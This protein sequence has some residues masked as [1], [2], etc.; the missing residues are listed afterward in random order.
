MLISVNTSRSGFQ[1]MGV[2]VF[3]EV[4]GFFTNPFLVPVL[5][6]PFSR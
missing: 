1:R 2:T 3:V 4:V 6:S 5:F